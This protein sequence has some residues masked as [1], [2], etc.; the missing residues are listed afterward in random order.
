MFGK[1]P[2][3]KPM[4]QESGKSNNLFSQGDLTIFIDETSYQ[5]KIRFLTFE[6]FF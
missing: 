6:S 5:E 3:Y 1:K 2:Y 4:N